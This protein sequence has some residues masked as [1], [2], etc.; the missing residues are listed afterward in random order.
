MTVDQ[1]EI[2]T[3]YRAVIV[4]MTAERGIVL[5]H[6]HQS[7][8]TATEFV[9]FLRKLRQKFGRQPLALFMDQLR[10]HKSKDVKPSYAELNIQPI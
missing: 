2:Y 7:A 8:V 6:T 3:G 5:T 10:V 4:A 1:R 9:H